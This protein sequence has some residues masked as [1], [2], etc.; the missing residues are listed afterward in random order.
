[1]SEQQART[2]VKVLH[3]GDVFLDCPFSAMSASQSAARRAETRNTFLRAVRYAAE[4]EIDVVLITG[5]L[6]DN[7]YATLETLE[8]LRGAFSS[9]P[10]CRF[11]ICPGPHDCLGDA[12]IYQ[13]GRLPSNV[14]VM[15]SVAPKRVVFEDI[16]TAVVGWAFCDRN[17]PGSPL[18]NN[19]A[20]PYEQGVTLV[21]GYATDG[22]E[23]GDAPVS[24][25]QIGEFGGEFTALSGG[26]LFDGFH[27]AASAT[28]AYSGALENSCY[29]EPGFGG[30]NLITLYPFA[31][32][33]GARV[34]TARVDFGCR[35]YAMEEFD[36]TGVKSQNELLNR[37][38]AV[39]RERGYGQETALRVILTGRTP[40]GFAVPKTLTNENFGLYVFELVDRTLPSFDESAV[41]RDMT[42]RGEVCRTLIPK[43]RTGTE[44]EKQAAAYALRVA[45]GALESRDISKL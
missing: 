7:S 39:I 30:A 35:R 14:T 44:E 9:A 3:F 29:E 26:N 4:Q 17:Y 25:S 24:V 20:E 19:S 12:S 5:N 18:E 1:M 21:A 22:G 45:L 33:Q 42:V 8:L 2:P 36:V 13:T 27:R 6:I 23:E 28:Y 41:A 34:E 31:V 32:G 40:I 38:T 16:G 43:M 11:V 37:I 15:D 10:A